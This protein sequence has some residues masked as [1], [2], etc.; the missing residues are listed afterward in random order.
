VGTGEN[1]VETLRGRIN[2]FTINFLSEEIGKIFGKC[3]IETV[4][5]VGCQML[6]DE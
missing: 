1:A 2:K 4:G 5:P 3:I 6:D